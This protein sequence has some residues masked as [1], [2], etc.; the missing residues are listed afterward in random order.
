MIESIANERVVRPLL[1]L[2]LMGLLAICYSYLSSTII[3]DFL[4]H[5]VLW[6]PIDDAFWV[7]RYSPF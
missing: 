2:S 6:H 5:L 4:T 1:G 7:C 3:R